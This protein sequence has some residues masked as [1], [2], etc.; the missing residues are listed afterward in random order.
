MKLK[1]PNNA[2]LIKGF[3]NHCVNS[4]G[5][6]FSCAR[7]NYWEKIKLNKNDEGRFFVRIVQDYKIKRFNVGRL[8]LETF[9]PPSNPKLQADHING[10]K[11]DDR[12]SNLQWLTQKEN[13]L[14]KYRY[15]GHKTH[16]AKPVI[17]KTMEGIFIKKHISQLDAAKEL[18]LDSS[19]ISKVCK[20]ILTQTG[21]YKW[22]LCQ[23]L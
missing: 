13:I 15:D 7:A 2:L 20:N 19:A 14:K 23:K 22:E 3:K 4:N 9:N 21:G 18:G 16:F 17:Q 10:D 6:V 8:V 1:L 12:L 5:E 11:T